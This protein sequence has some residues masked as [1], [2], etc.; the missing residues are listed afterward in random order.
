MSE[1]EALPASLAMRV[2]RAAASEYAEIRPRLH[3][4]SLVSRL[5]PA[6]VGS[7]LRAKLLRLIGFRIG[8]RTLI[9]G[10]PKIT[11][12]EDDCREPVRRYGLRHRAG[13]RARARR[14]GHDWRS[15]D[16]RAPGHDPD[17]LARDWTEGASR[18]PGDPEA[19]GDRERRLDR[20]LAPSF[21]RA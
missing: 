10:T 19:R 12:P 21:F 16:A 20:G 3:T 6:E 9:A 4:V 13:L 17:E 15:R 7:Q 1:P 11:G 14:A 18:R 5:L 2:F 8:D